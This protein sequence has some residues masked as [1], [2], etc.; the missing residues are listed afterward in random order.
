MLLALRWKCSLCLRNLDEGLQGWGEVGYGKRYA[1]FRYFSLAVVGALW[2]GVGVKRAN[3]SL[4]ASH[5]DLHN[6]L[7]D[8]SRFTTETGV[9]DLRSIFWFLTTPLCDY[10]A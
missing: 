6:H 7:L 3:L 1:G 10:V 5:A 2:G 4:T 9:I 8:L